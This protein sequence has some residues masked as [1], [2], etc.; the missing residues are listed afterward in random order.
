MQE[1][2]HNSKPL[3][4]NGAAA[5]P[6]KTNNKKF[7]EF[8]NAADTGG[9][10][11][12]LLYGYIS[13]TSWMGD[14]VTPK[15]FAADL[16]TIPATEDLT[17]RICSGGGDVWAAQ[18]I[19]ALLEN[20]IGTVTAQI[21]GIC[22]SAATIVASHCKVVKAAEDATYM[23][24]PIRVNPNGFVDMAGLQQLMDA[25]TVM[26]TNVL[27]HGCYVVVVCKRSQRARLCG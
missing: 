18:A 11:E 3:F 24:H 19:G 15:E 16:A 17:V 5:T 10:A 2:K 21:E 13:E 20:R 23:I 7:W 22:A 1:C 4:L 25:L 8:R 26:R 14:E 27:N 6:A 9:T 12:L